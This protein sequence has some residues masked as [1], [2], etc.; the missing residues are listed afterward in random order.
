MSGVNKNNQMANRSNGPTEEKGP[1]LSN[2]TVENVTKLELEYNS[3]DGERHKV[4]DYIRKN[5]KLEELKKSAGFSPPEESNLVKRGTN[6]TVEDPCRYGDGNETELESLPKQCR[7]ET[8]SKSEKRQLTNKQKGPCKNVHTQTECNDH[9]GV[10]TIKND[11]TQGHRAD[12]GEEQQPS[13]AREATP[14]PPPEASQEEAVAPE[15]PASATTSAEGSPWSLPSLMSPQPLVEVERP[16]MDP[17]R[18][19]TGS[20]TSGNTA[21]SGTSELEPDGAKTHRQHPLSC[22]NGKME[23]STSICEFCHLPKKRLPS[24]EQLASE[25]GSMLFCCVKIQEL[26]QYMIIDTIESYTHEKTEEETEDEQTAAHISEGMKALCELREQ[27]QKIDTKEY[28]TYLANHLSTN[29]SLFLMEKISFTLAS[30]NHTIANYAQSR[31][32]VSDKAHNIDD[33]FIPIMDNE[34][35]QKPAETVRQCYT[36]GQNFLTLFPDGTG[37][38]LYPSGNIGI[39]IACSKPTQFIF[40]IL[41]DAAKKPQI[42]AIFMSNGHAACYHHNGTLWTVLDPWGGSYLDET[43]VQKKHWAWW[44]FS[45]H[46][47]APPFQSITFILNSN[48]EVTILKQDQ[49]Y[50]SF[51]KDKEKVTFNVGSKL[52]LKD[53]KRTFEVKWNVMNGNIKFY[54]SSKKLE[55]FCLLNKIRSLL[56][57]AAISKDREIIQDFIYQLQKSFKLIIKLTDKQENTSSV[58]KTKE[59]Q[60]SVNK[61]PSPHPRSTLSSKAE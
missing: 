1:S 57:V 36:S 47:H 7:E 5:Q 4:E 18:P 43:G 37:Q 8:A 31:D 9:Y 53:P 28:I 42:Q 25:P 33:Y 38:V 46:V 12:S 15:P 40:I 55:I 49:I 34:L 50:L 22:E 39:L 24:V 44:D 58:L 48:I 35:I 56:R 27:I 29:G 10:T 30:A 45:Q 2:L 6:I 26:F 61:T 13:P 32:V 41:E 19:V 11:A 17:D 60:D 20:V 23:A 52:L 3:F 59:I 14:P 54:C 21:E 51:T 16:S